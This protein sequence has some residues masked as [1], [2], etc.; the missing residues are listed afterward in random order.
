MI[1]A[2]TLARRLPLG[3]ALVFLLLA[4]GGSGGGRTPT[5]GGGPAAATVN[6]HDFH[7]DPRSITV[8]PGTT[9]RW[10]RAG[11]DPAHTVTDRGGAFDSGFAFQQPGG[12]FQF[13]FT[14]QH[15][16]QTFEYWCESHEVC[17]QMRGSVRVGQ[18]AP[19]PSPG[20]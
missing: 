4:C 10:V 2:K 15:R 6:V 20:Y 17:C 19:P 11:T 13:T 1:D 9:V 7:F 8:E 3:A 18:S 5:E 12:A 16:G 14:E